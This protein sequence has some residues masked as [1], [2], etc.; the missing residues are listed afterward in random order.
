LQ[1]KKAE[2]I[3]FPQG[4]ALHPH[5]FG[6]LQ[7]EQLL[8]VVNHAYAAGGERIDIFHISRSDNPDT[9]RLTY[10]ST[11]NFDECCM[12]VL[13]DIVPIS[14]DEFYVTKY[15]PNKDPLPGRRLDTIHKIS[16][17]LYNSNPFGILKT[18]I[19]Y[20]KGTSGSSDNQC[21]IVGPK[22][23]MWNGIT[24]SP[25]GSIIYVADVFRK[26]VA[27][28]QRLQTNDLVLLREYTL[29]HYPDNIEYAEGKI[30]TGGMAKLIE[31]L[32]YHDDFIQ[33]HS[34]RPSGGKSPSGKLSH[35]HVSSL[36][37]AT[38]KVTI[39]LMH[40]GSMLGSLSAGIR[41]DNYVVAGS[42]LDN[43]ILVCPIS[44]K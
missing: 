32:A 25:D 42:W 15:I 22:G 1:L 6:L 28:F 20:C 18:V 40:D 31:G 39:H 38:Q 23:H 41:F 43:G 17:F 36:D 33:F 12:G 10:Q 44:K 21:K 13:N 34:T 24:S 16:G 11:M 19:Y 37:L 2:L 35:S 14:K 5:G 3:S 9:I 30:W 4:V 8:F 29:P 27:E 7:S 26:I